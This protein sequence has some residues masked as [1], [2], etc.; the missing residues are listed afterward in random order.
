MNFYDTVF[1][2]IIAT[3]FVAVSIHVATKLIRKSVGAFA[4]PAEDGVH[5][6]VWN[7]A[8]FRKV[9]TYAAGER[10]L[11]VRVP[12]D[13]AI[14]NVIAN[15]PRELKNSNFSFS[16]V[17]IDNELTLT[18]DDLPPRRFIEFKITTTLKSSESQESLFLKS[19]LLIC[20]DFFTKEAL[21]IDFW[22][23]QRLYVEST[24]T[25]RTPANV[26]V[27]CNAKWVSFSR[28]HFGKAEQIMSWIFAS[29]SI[30]GVF[31]LIAGFTMWL[32]HEN[33]NMKVID[34]GGLLMIS[35]TWGVMFAKDVPMFVRRGIN[36]K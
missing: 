16:T 13:F 1:A 4:A 28:C 17:I 2:T 8:I 5:L 34:W 14:T 3:L 26:S 11:V 31:L 25:I 10:G 35:G 9:S 23:P 19:G 33:P 24:S 15:T 27:L 7:S 36:E 29:T 12:A 22:K 21:C 18:I 32:I 20:P 6:V 30:A